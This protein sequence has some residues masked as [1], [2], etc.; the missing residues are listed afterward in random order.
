MAFPAIDRALWQRY[1]T[2][3]QQCGFLPIPA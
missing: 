2:Y 3:F 1:V